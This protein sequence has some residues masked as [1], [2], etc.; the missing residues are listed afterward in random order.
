[1]AAVPVPGDDDPVSRSL[2]N[3]GTTRAP[4]PPVPSDAPPPAVRA[5]RGGWRDPRLWVGVAIVAV[6][7]VVG[8]RVL[9]AADDTVTV[10]AVAA[11]VGPGQRLDPDDLVATRVRFADDDDLARYLTTGATLP[12]DLRLTRPVAAGELLPRDALG[13]DEGDDLVEVSLPVTP[14]R[15]PTSVTGGSVVD[16]Y[17]AHGEA[18]RRGSGRRDRA[19]DEPAPDLAGVTVVDAPVADDTFVDAAER[20]LVLAVPGEDVPGLLDLLGSLDDPVV[21]VALHRS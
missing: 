4:A 16:V 11:D 21:W 15:V 7:V 19:D 13:D 1:M 9:A 2:G 17:V 10:W 12:G 5:R 20:Q 14:L 6:S 8:A 18:D 3:P